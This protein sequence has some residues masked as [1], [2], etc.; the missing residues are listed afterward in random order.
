MRF[1]R[2]CNQSKKEGKN[3]E[4]IQSSTTPDPGYQWESDN[5]TTRHHKQE[6]RGQESNPVFA[7]YMYKLKLNNEVQGD[8][9]VEQLIT[10]LKVLSKDCSFDATYAN[11][12][13]RDQMVFGIKSKDMHKKLLKVGADLTL[14]KAIQVC[15]TYEYAQEQLKTMS[16]I[17]SSIGCSQ[18]R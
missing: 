18:L 13:I 17:G 8:N 16:T 4:S 3:Q 5:V 6:T 1:R 14:G 2:M 12:L 11:D 9:S 7:R 15:Q 10:Q